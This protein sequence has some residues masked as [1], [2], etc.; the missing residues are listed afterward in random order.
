MTNITNQI[1][2]YQIR[3]WLIHLYTS[4][5]LVTGFLALL[6]IYAGEARQAFIWFG[7]AMIIDATDGTMARAFQVKR[8]A[9]SFDGRK[10]DD[11]TDYLNYA[12]LPIFFAWRMEL[13][14]GWMAVVLPVVLIAAVYGFCQSGAKTDDGYFTGFPNFWNLAVLYLYLFAMPQVFN[15]LIL[16]ALSIL[17][18]VPI[19][20]VSYSTPRKARLAKLLSLVYAVMLALIILN[21]GGPVLYLSLIFPL[22]YMLYPLYQRLRPPISIAGEEI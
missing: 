6:A 2:W 18:F 22:I 4:L 21:Q 16:A 10:L 14:S 7:L 17:V 19:K 11:I 12:F 3:A 8:W 1:R 9:P 13:V 5:G 15:M 20:F